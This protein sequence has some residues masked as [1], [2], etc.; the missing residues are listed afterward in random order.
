MSDRIAF[1]QRM[2]RVKYEA[3][4][5]LYYATIKDHRLSFNAWMETIIAEGLKTAWYAADC[6]PDGVKTQ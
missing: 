1:T 3:L 6:P 2:D 5:S 4:Q